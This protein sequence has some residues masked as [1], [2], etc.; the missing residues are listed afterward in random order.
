MHVIFPT[1]GLENAILTP[2]VAFYSE[3][4][5]HKLHLEAIRVFLEN[6]QKI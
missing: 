3:T 5:L 2:H 6:H 4:V 1:F